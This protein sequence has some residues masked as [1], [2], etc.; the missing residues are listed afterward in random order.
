MSNILGRVRQ[1]Y[2]P[3]CRLV[4]FEMFGHLSHKT[5]FLSRHADTSNALRCKFSLIL[6]LLL[7]YFLAI[8]RSGRHWSLG[9]FLDYRHFHNLSAIGVARSWLCTLWW[10]N[11]AL[12]AD[13]SIRLLDRGL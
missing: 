11:F 4:S 5:T 1:P 7:A 12:A 3:H 8:V 6:Q 10:P 9:R 2:R 13:R